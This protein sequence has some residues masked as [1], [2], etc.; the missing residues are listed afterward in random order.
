MLAE[1]VNWKLLEID[2][3][4]SALPRLVYYYLWTFTSNCGDLPNSS[5]GPF[6]CVQESWCLGFEALPFPLMHDKFTKSRSEVWRKLSPSWQEFAKL[7]CGRGGA[8]RVQPVSNRDPA[9]CECMDTQMHAEHSTLCCMKM[10]RKTDHF[11]TSKPRL[12][13]MSSPKIN[14]LPCLPLQEIGP[15]TAMWRTRQNSFKNKSLKSISLKVWDAFISSCTH[16]RTCLIIE[17]RTKVI[18]LTAKSFH[19]RIP[20]TRQVCVGEKSLSS[21]AITTSPI[22]PK[23]KELFG[24]FLFLVRH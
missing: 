16:H 5:S 6:R 17:L 23:K 9:S 3:K 19:T 13:F 21:L 7:L 24:H 8:Q 4:D 20:Q 1:T 18:S 10:P 11:L 14:L 2:K 22:E 15:S 12:N